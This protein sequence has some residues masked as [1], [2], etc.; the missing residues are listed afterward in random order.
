VTAPL[1]ITEYFAFTP[2]C[3]RAGRKG[4]A[5]LPQE[6]P[7]PCRRALSGTPDPPSIC[8]GLDWPLWASSAKSGPL[9]P[10]KHGDRRICIG[11]VG[12]NTGQIST[13]VPVDHHLQAAGA[14]GCP[15]SQ[16]AMSPVV[17]EKG[18]KVPSGGV[19]PI[20]RCRFGS[21]LYSLAWSPQPA[22]RSLAVLDLCRK[23]GHPGHNR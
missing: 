6:R 23:T 22:Y 18:R 10:S 17:A 1:R 12:G 20:L 9:P 14:T 15:C 19:P 21:I 4:H 16:S 11:R 13:T 2:P 3:L 8:A 5:L 7:R